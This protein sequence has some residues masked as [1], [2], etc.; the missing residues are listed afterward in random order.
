MRGH[1]MTKTNNARH[2]AGP[3]QTPREIGVLGA[4]SIGIGGIVGGGIFA[5]LGLAGSQARG[6]T[7][8][9]FA[10]GGVVALLTA[11]SY[12]RLSLTYPGEGGTVMFLNRAF[13]NGLFAGG[14]NTLLLLSYVV[15]MAL[16]AA[17]FANYAGA[18][19]PAS[20]RDIGPQGLAP[21]IIVLLA[22][23]NFIGP[24]LVEKSEGFFNTGKL[25]ILLVFVLAGLV[26]PTLTVARLT[27]SDWVS[28]LEIVG[29]GMLVFLSYEGFELIANASDRIRNPDKTLPVAFYGSILT[30]MVLYVLI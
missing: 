15:I 1:R 25:T 24:E 30:A 5:T 26:S 11:Y 13:G 2:E 27:P 8:L 21:G 7:F 29:S 28:P 6:A 4:F 12:V 9:S 19:L 18:V 3:A 23:V 16:Y 14:L 22:F 17:A 10:V 20:W